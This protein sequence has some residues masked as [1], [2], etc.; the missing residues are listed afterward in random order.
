MCVKLIVQ[1]TYF[2]LSVIREVEVRE[3]PGR[4]LGS[5]GH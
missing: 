1:A 3:H 4:K 5:D 2:F